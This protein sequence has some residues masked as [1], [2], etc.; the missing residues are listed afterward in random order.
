MKKICKVLGAIAPAVLLAFSMTSCD[1]GSSG[2]NGIKYHPTNFY[3]TLTFG[4]GQQMW[5]YYPD[6]LRISEVY[7]PFTGDREV[8]IFV[9]IFDD[10]NQITGEKEV[11]T[12]TIRGGI[13]NFRLETPE[14][15]V[16]FGWEALKSRNFFYWEDAAIDAEGV[17]G[18]EFKFRTTK[19]ERLTLELITGSR[20]KI[21]QELIR[22][23]YVD[24][25]SRITGSAGSEGIIEGVGKQ[26]STYFY[27]END[28]DL[29]L[30]QGWNTLYRRQ[31]FYTDQRGDGRSG[32]T[33]LIQNPLNLKWVLY[34]EGYDG[35]DRDQEE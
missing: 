15:E 27:T 2:D 22:F 4:S 10:N 9:S 33:Q 24:T 23:I 14:A 6:W 17:R 18:N 20:E 13:L 1:T 32:I 5:E 21:S 30:G 25:P 26:T 16:L 31:T 12:G 7:S 8:I 35:Q 29:F 11:G 19:N 28:L 34:P 3:G